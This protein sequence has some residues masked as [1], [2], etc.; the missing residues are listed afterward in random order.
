MSRANTLF[1]AIFALLGTLLGYGIASASQADTQP[2]TTDMVLQPGTGGLQDDA[3]LDVLIQEIRALGGQLTLLAEA[4][5][6]PTAERVPVS[7]TP[8][9]QTASIVALLER[10]TTLIERLERSAASGRTADLAL[11]SPSASLDSLFSLD[12]EADGFTK[13]FN[14]QHLLWGYQRVLDTYGKPRT[15]VGD[16]SGVS[17]FYWT[18]KSNGEERT[19]TVRFVDG[20]VQSV[21]AT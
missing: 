2:S 1:P 19:L 11:G 20:Y 16:D 9:S 13:Q 5:T 12:L 8:A 18:E 14:Q 7:A 4:R 17:W 6:G 10:C 15:I 3:A 21:I